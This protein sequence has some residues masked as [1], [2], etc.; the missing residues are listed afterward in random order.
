MLVRYSLDRMGLLTIKP[1]SARWQGRIARH[2]QA[3]G[4]VPTP[5]DGDDSVWAESCRD[6]SVLIQEDY[7]IEAEMENLPVGKARDLRE[8]YDVTVRMDDNTFLSMVGASD[9]FHNRT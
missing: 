8:G 1:V 6:G 9:L 2:L 7:N 4:T 5:E 3:N